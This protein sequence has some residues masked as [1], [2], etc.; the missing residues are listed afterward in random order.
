MAGTCDTLRRPERG[1]SWGLERRQLGM[2][3]M[4]KEQAVAWA[5]LLI[6]GQ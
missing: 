5:A 1:K 6:W 4:D 2:W 3:S